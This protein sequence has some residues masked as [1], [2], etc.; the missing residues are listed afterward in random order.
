M[1]P[2]DKGE[3]VYRVSK[4]VFENQE[5]IDNLIRNFWANRVI[6]YSDETYVFED[7]RVYFDAT[8]TTARDITLCHSAG[9]CFTTKRID[10]ADQRGVPQFFLDVKKDSQGSPK[11]FKLN[12][13]LSGS[14][15]EAIAREKCGVSLRNHFES[16]MEV[17]VVHSHNYFCGVVTENHI[18]K[19]GAFFDLSMQAVTVTD[20]R[21]DEKNFYYISLKDRTADR[22]GVETREKLVDNVRDGFRVF[23]VFMETTQ[24]NARFGEY[25]TENTFYEALMSH[26]GYIS[27]IEYLPF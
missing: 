18:F 21:K 12:G 13:R 22:Y 23:E 24:N 15:V 27:N 25:V 5:F 3:M 19:P 9:Y 7:K 16:V 2:I 26:S 20:G 11:R 17:S 14:E 1:N 8:A 10:M 6:G 4:S